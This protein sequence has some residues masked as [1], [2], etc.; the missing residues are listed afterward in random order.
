MNAVIRLVFSF[1][2][3]IW[4]LWDMNACW[5]T[6][7]LYEVLACSCVCVCYVSSGTQYTGQMTVGCLLVN[8]FG[9]CWASRSRSRCFVYDST[10]VIT[11]LS[12][13]HT[14]RNIFCYSSW[15]FRLAWVRVSTA[16]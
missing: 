5:K 7:L 9:E 1:E 10:C 14:W 4:K 6:R 16:A 12:A 3:L 8:L 15:A 2:N 11:H 13:S